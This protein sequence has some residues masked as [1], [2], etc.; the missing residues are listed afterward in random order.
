MKNLKRNLT[1]V[2]V[3]LFICAAVGLNWSYNN[4]WGTSKDAYAEAEDA[5]MEKANTEYAASLEDEKNDTETGKEEKKKTS[6]EESKE[7]EKEEAGDSDYF[8]SARLTREQS[9]DEATALLQDTASSDSASQEVIDAAVE[10]IA[11]MASWTMQEAQLENMILSKDFEDC[12]VF[13][14]SDTVTVAVPAPE[15]GLSEADVARVM[16]TI[17]SETDYTA[18]QIRVV[19][20]K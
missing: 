12:I 16:E 6:G 19:E 14:N 7:T 9:R 3:L 13:I 1:I 15:E 2:V 10:E 5:A 4:K 17:T 20:V 18:S 11:A 8:S